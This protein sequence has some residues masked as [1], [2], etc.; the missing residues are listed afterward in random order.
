MLSCIVCWCGK[1]RGILRESE[2]IEFYLFG[3]QRQDAWSL[4]LLGSIRGPIG[5]VSSK[6]NVLLCRSVLVPGGGTD[7]P[8]LKSAAILL[9]RYSL[10]LIRL[11]EMILTEYVGKTK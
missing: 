6:C 7:V 4:H 3:S 5:P 8:V 2:A 9:L 10:I 11:K 1:S